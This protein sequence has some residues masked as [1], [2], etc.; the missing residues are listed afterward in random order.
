MAS[1]IIKHAALEQHQFAAHGQ[2]VIR[3]EN[4]ARPVPVEFDELRIRPFMSAKP[5]QTGCSVIC[6]MAMRTKW[7]I[8]NGSVRI[9]SVSR[10]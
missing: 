9:E 3:Q 10:T 1:Q 5:S 6:S 2:F 4:P 7:E 8:K